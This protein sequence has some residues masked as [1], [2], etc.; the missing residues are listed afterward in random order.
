MIYQSAHCESIG[1]SHCLLVAVASLPPHPSIYVTHV[2]FWGNFN[3]LF[4]YWFATSREFEFDGFAI[5]ATGAAAV[6]GI[7]FEDFSP[8]QW[9]ARKEEE[10]ESGTNRLQIKV[11]YG[12]CVCVCA[13]GD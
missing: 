12:M 5:R 10:E 11:D 1:L 6:D 2:Y 4:R 7:V 9:M 13:Y 8:K 3:R